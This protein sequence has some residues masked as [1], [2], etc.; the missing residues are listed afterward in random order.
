MNFHAWMKDSLDKNL[1]D[2]ASNANIVTPLSSL[3]VLETEE[4]YKRFNIEKNKEGLGNASM[5][6]AGA[7]PEPEEWALMAII[8][9]AL[10]L[11]WRKNKSVKF[12]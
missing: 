10:L 7:V 8:A 4:D 9:L 5:N 2:L 6:N 11:L 1:I 3:I 12:A